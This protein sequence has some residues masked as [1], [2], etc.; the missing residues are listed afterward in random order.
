MGVISSMIGISGGIVSTPMQQTILK[1][2]IKNSIANTITAAIFCS[3]TASGFLLI[4]A[5][6]AGDFLLSDVLIT[7][8]FLIPGNIIGGQLGGFFTKR[9]HINFVR[10]FFA[11]IAFVIGFRILTE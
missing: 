11:I 9:L 2:P 7:L 3:L 6:N 1:I 4:T 5:S 10:I 8:I